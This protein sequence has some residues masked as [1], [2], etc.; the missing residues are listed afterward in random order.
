[1]KSTRVLLVDN[2]SLMR[3]SFKSFL[4]HL[5]KLNIVGEC[6]DGDQVIDKLKQLE[7]DLIFMDINMDHI[8]GFSTT[9]L[10]KAFNKNIKVIFF[11]MLAYDEIEKEVVECGADGYIPKMGVT[12]E[13][14]MKELEKVIGFQ[15][16]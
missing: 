7:V 5:P 4:G 12:H 11:S 15:A 1:M 16:D 13:I 2:S 14:L 10:V 6:S 3:E 9:R 8:D